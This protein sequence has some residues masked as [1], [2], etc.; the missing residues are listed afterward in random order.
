MSSVRVVFHFSS[1]GEDHF[2]S[3]PL[4]RIQCTISA[5]ARNWTVES[6]SVWSRFDQFVGFTSR[7][8]RSYIL[9]PAL[10]KLACWQIAYDAT[11]SAVF[12]QVWPRTYPL[13]DV[14]IRLKP[15]LCLKRDP[16]CFTTLVFWGRP[17]LVACMYV[18][19]SC[20]TDSFRT[21]TNARETL[22]KAATLW[23]RSNGQGDWSR[24]D[25]IVTLLVNGN[26]HETVELVT[27]FYRTLLPKIFAMH[28]VVTLCC[29][30]MRI[31]TCEWK[32]FSNHW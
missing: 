29:V 31:D 2:R 10:S 23:A 18:Y 24:A 6:I 8:L 16:K 4:V 30:A 22:E 14:N 20:E 21:N 13:S 5:N 11:V 3:A 26:W 32:R 17:T 9:W 25:T 1:I 7:C 28:F 19:S 12:G 15:L 27:K